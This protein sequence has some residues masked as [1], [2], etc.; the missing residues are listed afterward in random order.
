MK[1]NKGIRGFTLIEMAIY[2]TIAGL[3]LAAVVDEY[4]RYT[5][6]KAQNTTSVNGNTVSVA[7]S[8]FLG[9][10]GRLPCPADPTLAP[11]HQHAGKEI[12]IIGT[13][14][15]APLPSGYA[16]QSLTYTGFNVVAKC[17]GGVC[18]TT[19]GRDTGE[20]GNI[21][22][23]PVITG[24]V[25]YKAL[26]I[27]IEDTIDGWDNKYTYAVSEYLTDSGSFDDSFGVIDDQFKD[28]D[29]GGII[30]S[31]FNDELLTNA[32]AMLAIVSHGPDGK[33][34]YNYFGQLVAACVGTDLD[35]ENC[36][37]DATY[38]DTD[39]KTQIRSLGNNNTFFDDYYSVFS[40][41]RDSDKWSY[42]SAQE[43]Q[44]KTDGRVGIGQPLPQEALHVNGNVL[45]PE[46]W[47]DEDGGY[48]DFSH[49]DCMPSERI[50]GDGSNC[51]GGMSSKLGIKNLE[52]VNQLDLSAIIPQ[53]CS[54]DQIAIGIDASGGVIC[55]SP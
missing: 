9:I 27:T 8:R 24:A 13:N 12:C 20:D 33:G 34:A 19:G 29:N 1:H 31:R 32:S 3:I 53:E 51:N 47:A 44:N 22:P 30:N 17:S 54:G 45:T 42:A 50:G 43:I 35:T 18:R 36:D 7:M 48:C 5:L 41:S 15:D 16:S 21:I 2:V 39:A 25:P 37:G 26:N 23:D 6:Q 52:C 46:I 55:T 38:I 10:H 14:G 49:S 40:V 4:Q 11:E 28:L